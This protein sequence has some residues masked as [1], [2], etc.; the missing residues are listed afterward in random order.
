L[1]GQKHFQELF[2]PAYQVGPWFQFS[3]AKGTRWCQPDGIIVRPEDILI[4]EFKYQHTP[5]AW[6]QLRLL[7]QPVCELVFRRP[8]CV[9][10]C[11]KWYDCAVAYPE[12][13]K[14]VE[15]PADW[16]SQ[17]FGVHIWKP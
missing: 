4:V 5:D 2:G 8:A 7:Y 6:A 10:E 12:P 17:E 1:A 15:S 11:V 3:D 9:L 13:V 14:L 16:H